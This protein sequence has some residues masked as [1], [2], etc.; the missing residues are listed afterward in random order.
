[1][2]GPGEVVKMT[3]VQKVGGKGKVEL[4]GQHDR[5]DSLEKGM[6]LRGHEALGQHSVESSGFTPKPGSSLV[7]F[8]QLAV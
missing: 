6:W 7:L 5:T 8:H 4:G 2:V 1:M 3:G